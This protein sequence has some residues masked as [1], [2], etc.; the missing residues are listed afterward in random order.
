MP[1]GLISENLVTVLIMPL[2]C[3]LSENM[4]LFCLLYKDEKIDPM[5]AIF[6]YKKCLVILVGS[7]E[8]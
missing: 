8:D 4:C 1:Q 2:L 5:L 3:N 6:V 7:Q